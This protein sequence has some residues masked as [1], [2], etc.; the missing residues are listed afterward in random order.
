MRLAF[1]LPLL[2]AEVACAYRSREQVLTAAD[3]RVPERT[4]ITNY[5]SAPLRP[6]S[7]SEAPPAASI[8][9]AV[10]VDEARV[11][12][13]EGGEVCFDLVV[14]TGTPLDTP[15]S[16]M[17]VLVDGAPARVGDETVSVHDHSFTGERDVLVADHVSREA[18]GSLRLT[19]PIEAVFRVVERRALV[20][21]TRLPPATGELTLEVII[22]QDDNRG[23]WGEKFVWRIEG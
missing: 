11:A 9:R 7:P 6:G 4:R 19:A 21:R 18:Y 1:V 3:L 10:L 22:V 2:L 20:C 15:L 12:R 16:E 13:V 14:R 5:M 17:R 23:N 8:S